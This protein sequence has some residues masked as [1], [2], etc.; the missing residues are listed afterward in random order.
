[1]KVN[2]NDK[3]LS[4]GV[5]RYTGKTMH[6]YLC[7]KTGKPVTVDLNDGDI[8]VKQGAGFILKRGGL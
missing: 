3:F 6:T 2:S 7:S 5:M 1:M 4:N 8:L